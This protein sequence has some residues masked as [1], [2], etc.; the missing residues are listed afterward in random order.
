MTMAE[1]EYRTP[2]GLHDAYLR[3][4][5]VDY[6]QA[7]LQLEIDW[8]VSVPEERSLRSDSL[9]TRGSLLISG[10]EYLVVEPPRNGLRE[11]K[12]YAPN[13]VQAYATTDDEIAIK[14]LPDVS[15]NAFRHSLYIGYWESFIYIAGASAEVS[16]AELLVREME[17]C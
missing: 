15:D 5:A 11:S 4:F 14:H 3:G 10:L 2:N 1:V 12:D 6:E 7:T 9:W 8:L 13:Q 17:G 16:P